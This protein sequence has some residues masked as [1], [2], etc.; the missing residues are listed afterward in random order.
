MDSLYQ[1]HTHTYIPY[2]IGIDYTWDT[3]AHV[4]LHLLHNPMERERLIHEVRALGGGKYLTVI[5]GH[6]C[7]PKKLLLG[8]NDSDPGFLDSIRNRLAADEAIFI[9][10]PTPNQCTFQSR[11]N[12]LQYYK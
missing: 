2:P 7:L 5:I 8:A 1:M 9:E 4:Y 12:S 6:R 10:S 11:P 3:A